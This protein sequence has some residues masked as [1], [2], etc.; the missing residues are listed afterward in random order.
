MKAPITLGYIDLSFHAA[1]A[2]V[3]REILEEHG[4]AVTLRAAP[5]EAMFRLLEADAVDLVSSAWLPASHGAYLAPSLDKLEKLG[6]LYEPY[7]IWGVPDYVPADVVASVDDLKKPEALAR[8]D[9]RIAG[10][11]PGAGI[12]RFSQAMIQ[13]Y[14]LDAHAYRFEAGDEA[15]CFDNFRRAVDEGRWLVLPLWHPQF[16][17]QDYRIRAL[18]EPKGMLGGRDAAT[19]VARKAIL[20]SIAPRALERLR[21][22]YLGNAAVSGLEHAI[23]VRG[24]APQ[25]VAREWLARK[26]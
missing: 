1:S 22:L 26:A 13:G 6:A 24:L 23:R 20:P 19:L 15:S 8:M 16:L 9:R 3:V 11:N 10:I 7:C 12:S 5:H 25:T 14:G 17:H 18:E 21:G 4:H 2:A